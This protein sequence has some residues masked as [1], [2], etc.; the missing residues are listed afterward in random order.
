M[1][2]VLIVVAL[3]VIN[4]NAFFVGGRIG[5][6]RLQS[7]NVIYKPAGIVALSLESG[8]FDEIDNSVD[9]SMSFEL[10]RFGYAYNDGDNSVA[11]WSVGLKPMIWTFSF[12]QMYVQGYLS[13]AF[14]AVHDEFESAMEEHYFDGFD[15]HRFFWGSGLAIGYRIQEKLSVA[16]SYDI[17]TLFILESRSKYRYETN[18]SIAGIGLSV[19]YNLF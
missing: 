13:L 9:Y 2:F 1:R 12:C 18:Y 14:I 10:K 6:S 19:M 4:A 7:E 5:E 17:N 11:F 3:C 16:L 15:S 8:F